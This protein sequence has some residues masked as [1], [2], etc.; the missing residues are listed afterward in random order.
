MCAGIKK[1]TDAEYEDFCK[2][3]KIATVKHPEK[4][5][6]KGCEVPVSFANISLP[7]TETTSTMEEP[8]KNVTEAPKTPTNADDEWC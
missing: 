6:K 1:P 3:L 2:Y 5:V 4:Y 8:V 7:I